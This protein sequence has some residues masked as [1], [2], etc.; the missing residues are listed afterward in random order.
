MRAAMR[1]LQRSM[2]A[3]VFCLT[4]TG[5]VLADEAPPKV[6]AEKFAKFDRDGDKQLSVNEY[7]ATFAAA[8]AA[9]ALRDFDL[10][11]RNADNQL[12]LTEYWALPTHPV[13]QRGPLHDP[14][15]DVVDQFVGVLDSVLDDWDQAPERTVPVNQFVAAFAKALSEPLTSQ[16]LRDVDP[17]SDTKVTR[18]EA[19]RFV[20]IQSGVR[21]SGGQLLRLPDSRVVQHMQFLNADQNRDD[22]LDK[23][24]F[25]ARAWSPPGKGPETFDL[26]DDDKDGFVSWLEWSKLRLTDT[27]N[28]FRRMDINVDG[29]L[30]PAEVLA[31]TPDWCKLS[32]QVSFPAFDRDRNG[33]LSLDEFR[34][35]FFANPIANWHSL[36]ADTDDD[37]SLSRTE[38]SFGGAFPVMRFVY[39]DLFDANKDGQLDGEEFIFKRKIPREVYV[40]NADGTGW[41]KLFGIKGYPS[42]GSPAV[43]PDGKWIALDGHAPK[44][45][46]NEQTMLITDFEGNNLRKIGIG[47]MPTWSKDGRSLSFSRFNSGIMVVNADGT[48]S[49]EITNGA[50][51]G[52]QWS[53]DGKQ[54]AYYV[55][56]QIMLLD[57]ATEKSKPIYNASDYR[58]I[59]W[60]MTWSP[61]SQRIC[62]KGL[63]L[64]GTED[65]ATVG[66]DP[67]KPN[68]KVHVSGKN[69]TTDFAWHPSGDR[70]IFV[71]YCP[72][73]AISQ[74]YE[75]NPNSADPPKLVAGQDPKSANTAM[76]WTPDGKQ[77]IV[78]I[79]D[80]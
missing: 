5:G 39:F 58:Q 31:G 16:M 71:M 55:G 52:A 38:F 21:R 26:T 68:L 23:N 60:N 65:V 46:L 40:M 27:L 12:S 62:F 7:Q 64:D 77:L 17:N 11:D 1:Q 53:P 34:L 36:I 9:V 70:L 44:G 24:E 18:A 61:D 73:R 74:L 4:A 3:A 80:Y 75:F 48:N 29:Q 37:G 35:T 10:V 32:G 42:L 56:R 49:R 2:L 63:K 67:N 51:W 14:L 19:R 41:K 50:G 66:I 28:E 54:I 45:D 25:L 59:Y 20:E 33:K 22:R 76:C 30:E 57:V 47:M 79:G 13:G 69:I 8:N 78:V 43:S 72:E 15:T 6:I